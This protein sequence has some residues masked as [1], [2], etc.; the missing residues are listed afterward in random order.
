MGTR[1]R[2]GRVWLAPSFTEGLSFRATCPE[3]GQRKSRNLL[4][5]CH[6]RARP[7]LSPDSSESN[8]PESSV[9]YCEAG[10]FAGCGNL[11]K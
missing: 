4:K 3:Q 6:S 11:K 1:H 2:R 7:A 8:G 10:F 5:N 9:C